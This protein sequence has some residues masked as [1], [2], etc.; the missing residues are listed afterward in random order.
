MATE[1]R[2]FEQFLADVDPRYQPFLQDLY[3]YLADHGCKATCEAK[4][5]GPFASYKH[6]K[7]KKSIVNF[8]SRK[9]GMRIR[10][11]GESVGNYLD[12]LQ[13]LPEEMVQSIE[14]AGDCTRLTQ[15]ACSPKCMGYDVII[16]GKRFQKCRY[17]GFE[18]PV[19]EGN[20]PYIRS[21]IECEVNG[22]A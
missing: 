18:F 16:D 7:S 8:L 22:R 4:K 1:K 12:F 17:G 3:T 13:T 2:T 9:T 15:N 6:T 19:T 5:S 21:F 14:G 20:E 11:Y 10:I